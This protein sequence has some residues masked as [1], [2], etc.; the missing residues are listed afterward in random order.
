M[1]TE[2]KGFL[3]DYDELVDTLWIKNSEVE[4]RKSFITQGTNATINAFPGCLVE[5]LISLHFAEFHELTNLF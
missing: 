3:E 4:L 2:T 1:R 5:H